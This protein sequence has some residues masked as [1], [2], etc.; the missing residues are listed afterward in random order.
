M[1]SWIAHLTDVQ[2]SQFFSANGPSQKECNYKAK[3]IKGGRIIPAPVQG[4]SSYTVIAGD[5]VVQFRAACAA[6]D[7]EF[8]RYVEQAYAGFM[9]YHSDSG[10]LAEL[11]IYTMDKIGGVSLY[12]ARDSLYQSNCYRLRQTLKDFARFFASAWHNTPAAMP[13]LTGPLVPN[14]IDLLENNIHVDP[15][16]GNLTGI[17]DWADAEI[18]PFGISLG[19]VENMLGIPTMD[20]KSG[21]TD[22]VYHTNH[23][24]LRDLFYDELYRAIG[25]V[26]SEDEKHIEEA[27]LVGLFLANGWRYDEAWNRFPAREGEHG[28]QHLDTVLRATCD[29]YSWCADCPPMRTMV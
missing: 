6:L 20:E 15:N 18:S 29:W 7:L 16:T 21:R 10:K 17:C 11:Y 8:L 19:A 12:L 1:E 25:S 4:G 14:H 23:Q 3:L 26:S 27:R 22:H 24:E 2:I 5:Y 13:P 28:L 9:P